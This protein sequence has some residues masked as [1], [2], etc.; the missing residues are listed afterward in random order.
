M[1]GITKVKASL[2]RHGDNHG[3]QIDFETNYGKTMTKY[4]LFFFMGNPELI[5][6]YEEACLFFREVFLVRWIP[7]EVIYKLPRKNVINVT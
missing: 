3:I 7:K 4:L 2:L 6:K 5:L 1:D